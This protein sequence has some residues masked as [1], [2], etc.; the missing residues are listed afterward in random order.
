MT[1]PPYE[2]AAPRH[3]GK[4][5][6]AATGW[7]ALA[8]AYYFTLPIF[9]MISLL[10]WLLLAACWLWA[11]I[12]SVVVVMSLL[13]Q[14][15]WQRAVAAAMIAAAAGLGTWH[16]DWLA[17]YLSSQV[18]LHHAELDDLAAQHRRGTLPADARLPWQ[19]RY[20]SIDGRVHAQPD[21]AG[22]YLPMWQNW[23]GE[24]G[25]GLVHLATP[26]DQDTLIQT[27]PGGQGR[28]RRHIDGDWW[29]VEGG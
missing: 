27:A 11:V 23:R 7:L 12:A 21:A 14:R 22:L 6:V 24:A 26:P 13:K 25:G 19:I 16:A 29:W 8:V 10:G 15:R 3:V 2:P 28:P 17:I 4:M 18:W 1:D 9:D 20:L 5:V